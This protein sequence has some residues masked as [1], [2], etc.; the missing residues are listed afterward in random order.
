[1]ASET[2]FSDPFAEVRLAEVK[3]AGRRIDSKQAIQVKDDAGEWQTRGFV[4]KDY[5]L[6]PNRLVQDLAEDVISRAPASLGGFQQLKTL[7]NGRHYIAY[8]ASRNAVVDLHEGG[9]RLQVGLMAWNSYDG[10]RKIG[11]EV[12]ALNAFCTNQYHSRN[13]FGFFAWKHQPGALAIDREDALGGLATGVQNVIAMAPAIMALR[14]HPL[15]LPDLREAKKG[16]G[17]PQSRWGDVLDRLGEEEPNHFGLFQALTHVATHAMEGMTALTA[18]TAITEFF[19][20]PAKDV[21][22]HTTAEQVMAGKA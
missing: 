18:G 19:L 1:M 22:H 15:G 20:N 11:F 5:Q 4:G 6:F 8:F 9:G 12:Y 13:R 17:L 14:Q 10:T 2:K 3:V 7:W 21:V 16:V